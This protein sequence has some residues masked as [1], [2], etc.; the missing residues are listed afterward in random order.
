MELGA[1]TREPLGQIDL[2]AKACYDGILRPIAILAC[3]RYG[4]P[5]PMC[6]WLMSLLE[7]QEH[8][9]ILPNGRSKR[10]YHSTPAHWLHGIGQG[11]TAAPVI[12]LFISSIMM[13]SMRDW[14]KGVKWSSPQETLSTQRYADSYV[15]D[16]TL[17]INGVAEVKELKR[18]MET[19]LTSYQEM[20]VWTGGA[21]TLSKCFFQ[22]T[23]VGVHSR[24]T[25]PTKLPHPCSAHSTP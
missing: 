17:W 5:I 3:Y 6:C 14:S 18:G 9:L 20:L 24:R 22:H 15:D 19:D 4:L 16:T 7:T 13:I 10:E 23:R 12:W 1:L 21:L 8:H 2:D 11:S 25:A